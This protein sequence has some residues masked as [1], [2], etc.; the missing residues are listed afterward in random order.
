MIQRTV[1]LAALVA[2]VCATAPAR[3]DLTTIY[4][5]HY[6]GREIELPLCEWSLKP[7]TLSCFTGCTWRVTGRRTRVLVCDPRNPL[8][9]ACSYD[10]TGRP[11]TPTPTY[12]L[13]PSRDPNAVAT[14]D[15][16]GGNALF[17]TSL[18][19]CKNDPNSA[20]D[21]ANYALVKTGLGSG[22]VVAAQVTGY[23]STPSSAYVRGHVGFEDFDSSAAGLPMTVELQVFENGAWK[24]V[25]SATNTGWGTE[26]EVDAYVSGTSDVRL[27]VRIARNAM[28]ERQVAFHSIRLFGAQCYPDFANPGSC[29]N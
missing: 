6:V 12:L 7:A 24:V 15:W 29:V 1:S 21:P 23:V 9:D 26:V 10:G 27:E 25:K 18:V 14:S 19:Q 11:V 4:N 20:V 13:A 22:D 28:R 5:P 16:G 3:A 2:A 17:N 8:G